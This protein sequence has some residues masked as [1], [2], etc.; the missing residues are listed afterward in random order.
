MTQDKD[1]LKYLLKKTCFSKKQARWMMK[2]GDQ[3]LERFYEHIDKN[4]FIDAKEILLILEKNLGSDHPECTR[5][6]W[7]YEADTECLSPGNL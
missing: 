3:L 1:L 7:L 6:R 5:A 2:E 4:R